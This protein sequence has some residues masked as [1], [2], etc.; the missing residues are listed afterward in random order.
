MSAKSLR[1]VPTGD[2]RGV[3]SHCHIVLHGRGLGL[4]GI[5]FPRGPVVRGHPGLADVILSH[6]QWEA[7]QEENNVVQHGSQDRAQGSWARGGPSADLVGALETSME[8]AHRIETHTKEGQVTKAPTSD[9][10]EEEGPLQMP[11]LP[12]ISTLEN[13]G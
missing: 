8:A 6:D 4:A 12:A 3:H 1:G 2:S 9:D 11:D 13:L 7:V 5:G 10:K